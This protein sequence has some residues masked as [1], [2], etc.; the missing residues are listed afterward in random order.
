MGTTCV[1]MVVILPEVFVAYVGDSRLYL[2]RDGKLYQLTEDHTVVFEMV[3][4]G[5]LTREQARHHEDRNVLSLSMGGRAE[6]AA[7]YWENPMTARDG[8]RF[9]LCSDGLHDLVGEAELQTIMAGSPAHQ[10]VPRLIDLLAAHNSKE[11]LLAELL[12]IQDQTPGDVKLRTRLG[13]LS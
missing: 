1:A 4:K 8:D 3:R 12:P 2:L 7:S 6:I 13:Q 9:L 5:L 11:E 10:A